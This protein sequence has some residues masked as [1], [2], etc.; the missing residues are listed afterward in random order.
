MLKKTAILFLFIFLCFSL[1]S[2]K[3]NIDSLINILNT[4]DKYEQK[5]DL[6]YRISDYY[7]KKNEFQKALEYLQKGIILSK[8]NKDTENEL[9]FSDLNARS[10][11]YLSEYDKSLK[12]FKKMLE[13]AENTD[14]EKYIGL[15]YTGYLKNYW[16]L[17]NYEKA[18]FYADKAVKIFEKINDEFNKNTV[19][20]N[21]A[22]I[23]IDIKDYKSAEKTFDLILNDSKNFNDTLL[24]ASIY[25]K[26][27]VINFFK[28]MYPL[29]RKYYSEAHRL[30][31]LKD[32]SLS[33]AIQTG[34][35]GETYEEE[36]K[37]SKALKLYKYAAETE[38]KYNYNSGL[39]FLYEALGRTYS[40]IG[41]YNKTV[42]YYKK[43]LS[44][45]KKTGEKRELPNIYEMLHTLYA[46]TGNYKKAYEF[47]L[48]LNAAKDSVSGENVQNQINRI[49]IKYETEKT[50]KENE[51]LRIK[52]AAQKK[53][54]RK[55][56]FIIIIISGFLIAVIIFSVLLFRLYRKN[57][58]IRQALSDK[59]KKL[60]EAYSEIRHSIDYA[61]KIQLTML[62]S[63]SENL[64]IFPEFIIIF[65][66]AQTL[67][68]DFYWTKKIKDTL[69]V[70][71]GDSTGHG[72]QSAL[73]SITGMS[74]LNE[75]VT[76]DLIQT[77]I[78][79]NKL[80][81]KI[82]VLLNQTGNITEHK[83]GWDMSIFS[84]NLTTKQLQFSGAYNS[85]YVIK[86]RK[87]IKTIEKYKADRQPVAVHIKETPFTR[88]NLILKEGDIIW[89]FTDGFPDQYNELNGKKYS[90]A[91]LKK[92]LL[93]ISSEPLKEQ[94]NIL[95]NEFKKWKAGYEQID[96]ILIMGIKI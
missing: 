39:I 68:G 4:S 41:K 8:K 19:L 10:Y 40:K 37:Y 43:A 66:P 1:F 88:K 70:A 89:M 46:K 80:R 86:N 93:S 36:K 45:I 96:D 21:F 85:L 90:T 83:D 7:Y 59:N 71:A 60:S 6:I 3:S 74:F 58:K 57:K 82:K 28:S 35:I 53:Q 14:N 47:S 38:R 64:K 51:I 94:K 33:A 67:S 25:E 34:N 50:E 22:N 26:K 62:S 61:G 48:K 2:R 56:F 76:E 5:A 79:L 92:L 23:Y 12:G 81:D 42:F 69:F 63:Y 32:D 55:Q 24:I 20:L 49:K 30:Y 77:D 65:K 84:I 54:N 18:I 87:G 29:A 44:I 75:I 27:G 78:I 52:E 73:L 9:R 15:A 13:I 31:I 91:R 17:G 72:I 11:L 16:R 95:N